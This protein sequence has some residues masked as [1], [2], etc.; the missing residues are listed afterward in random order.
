MLSSID[1]LCIKSWTHTI[2]FLPVK[3]IGV[4]YIV[5]QVYWN[6]RLELFT[7]IEMLSYI[8]RY[9]IEILNL[10][11]HT[12]GFAFTKIKTGFNYIL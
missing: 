4:L 8:N 6:D 2:T 12:H 3:H 1:D 11:L 7:R 9:N 5:K 10:K